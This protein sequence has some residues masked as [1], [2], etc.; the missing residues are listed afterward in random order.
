M[1][2]CIKQIRLTGQRGGT[3]WFHSVFNGFLLTGR[4]RRLLNTAFRL[5]T[6]RNFK[7]KYNYLTSCPRRNHL[8]LNAF[9]RYIMYRLG[10]IPLY[11]G[12]VKAIRNLR[13]KPS[14]NTGSS[15]DLIKICQKV[16]GSVQFPNNRQNMENNKNKVGPS[17][18]FI[19]YTFEP[20][21]I[22]LYPNGH[23]EFIL[24]HIYVSISDDKNNNKNQAVGHAI[25]AFA[26]ITRKKVGSKFVQKTVRYI[27]D[28]NHLRPRQLDWLNKD[29]LI[30]YAKKHVGIEEPFITYYLVY[31]KKEI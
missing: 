19:D 14:V 24:N 5:Y 7:P 11:P 25:T 3:C 23:P 2:E 6:V 20:E 9:W 1:A 10:K 28:S 4:G 12:E 30:N 27:Y 22:T 18:V 16:F 13:N 8:D 15:E 31:I 21:Y 26:C 29:K 17:P